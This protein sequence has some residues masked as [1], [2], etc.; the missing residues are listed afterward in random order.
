MCSCSSLWKNRWCSR[1]YC[2]N[3]NIRIL[4]LQIFTDTCYSSACTNTCYK[5]INLS[6]C[7]IPDLRSC[8]LSV[9]FRVCR[10][11]ELTCNEAV[12]DLLRELLCLCDRTLHT[13][14]TFSQNDLCAVCFDDIS[15]FNAHG[16]RHNDDC[17][18]TLCC[19]DRCKTDTCISGCRLNDRSARL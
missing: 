7:I 17:L 5:D 14:C 12:R 8:C 1:L 11:Y 3:L 4:L 10:I 13:L 16:L 6:V 15:S 18:I 9:C 19:S 2:Y